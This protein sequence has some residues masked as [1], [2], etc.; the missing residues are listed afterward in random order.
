MPKRDDKKLLIGAGTVGALGV[1]GLA[2]DKKLEGKAQE[3]RIDRKK[4]PV[5]P[6]I[7]PTRP[8]HPKAAAAEHAYDVAPKEFKKYVQKQRLARRASKARG[9]GAV[10]IALG[11]PTMVGEAQ[12]VDKEGGRWAD[13]F[14][15]FIEEVLLLPKGSTGR[16]LTEAER[17]ALNRI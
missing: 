2:I 6:E 15:K 16:G 12:R 13:R 4:V 1:A 10:G 7:A 11:A 5:K 9:M 8:M 17:R 14:G 3:R